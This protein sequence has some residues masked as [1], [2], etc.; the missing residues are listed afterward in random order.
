MSKS[1][2]NWIK[3]V[4]LA[5]FVYVLSIVTSIYLPIIIAIVLAFILNPLVNFF[6][7]IRIK[8]FKWS[9]PRGLAVLLS[10]AVAGMCIAIIAAFVLMPFINEFDKFAASLPQLM[11]KVQK[12]TIV[13]QERANEVTLPAN[14]SDLLQQTFSS[15]TAFFISVARR[16]VNSIFDFASGIIELVVVPVLTYYFIKDWR[17]LKEGFISIFSPNQSR[18][19]R[20]IIEEIAVVISGYIRGQFW[21]S[22]AMGLTVFSGMYLLGVD[23]PLVLGLLATLTETIPIIGPI[24]GA[25]PAILLALVKSPA[26]AFKVLS[27]FL[28]IHQMENHVIVPNVMG[29]TIDLHPATIIIVLLIGGQLFGIVGMM[30]AV[31][32]AAILKVIFRHLWFDGPS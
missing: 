4:I 25:V 2:V 27:F 7:N 6:C 32:V 1:S 16:L 13:I 14:L 9:I 17:I 23:Y 24:V 29:H 19:V 5:I 12:L 30:L 31:P 21:I 15:A 18:Q 11:L 26:L 10:F 28:I 3:L 22:I 8:R 20:I